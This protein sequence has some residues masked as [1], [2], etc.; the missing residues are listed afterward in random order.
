M[1]ESERIIEQ[2]ILPKSF[3]EEEERCGFTVTKELKKIW[4]VAI[5]QLIEFDRVCRKHNLTYYLAYGSL[6]GAI[7]HKGFIPWDDDMDVVMPRADYDN[8]LELGHEFQYPYF[9]QTPFSDPGY[10]FSYAKLRN[11]NTTCITTQFRYQKINWGQNFDIFPLDN[12]KLEAGREFYEKIR[13]LGTDLS[14]YMRSSN[15]TPPNE[16]ERKRI[17][18][19]SGRDPMEIYKEIQLLA[20]S[21][22]S[23]ETDYLA[24]T[25]AY[26][27]G[28]ERA[29]FLKE[30]Y[31]EAMEVPF[32][33][34]T[35]MVPVGYDR[36][37]R[38]TY[39]N[40]M[41][42]PPVDKRGIW[43]GNIIYNPDVPYI[44]EQRET[45]II[46]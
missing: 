18:S 6:L 22:N 16:I 24:V 7:R 26:L 17:Q 44:E 23:E 29:L 15:P 10:F 12:M 39:G 40:Y 46:Y 30:D 32:E 1:T 37:L 8:L 9:L 28:F 11:T 31:S 45:G 34:I 43:H 21:F 13:A 27:Y 3:F 19:Y 36:I 42:Y 38:N 35:A 20:K 2:G 33:G 14:N 4:A 41:E 5:D 25:T